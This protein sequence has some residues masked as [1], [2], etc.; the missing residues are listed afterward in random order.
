M[1]YSLFLKALSVQVLFCGLV[2]QYPVTSKEHEDC[3]V[4]VSGC[5]LRNSRELYIELVQ[6]LV[7]QS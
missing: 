4:Y 7:V 5:A 3:T 2:S 6:S 1:F